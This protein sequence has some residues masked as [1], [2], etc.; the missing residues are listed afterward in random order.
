M[1]TFA[2]WL[3]KA[4]LWLVCN[5]TSTPAKQRAEYKKYCEQFKKQP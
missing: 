1:L 5:K 2:E 4:P 3:R